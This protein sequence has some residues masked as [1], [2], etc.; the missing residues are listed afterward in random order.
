MFHELSALLLRLLLEQSTQS[1]TPSVLSKFALSLPL[2]FPSHYSLKDIEHK[3]LNVPGH[4][5]ESE[6]L[7]E[8]SC[9]ETETARQDGSL[10]TMPSVCR[11]HSGTAWRPWE[12]ATSRTFRPFRLPEYKTLMAPKLVTSRIAVHY[13][14][15]TQ[16]WWPPASWTQRSVSAR[17]RWPSH[18]WSTGVGTPLRT[19]VR[20]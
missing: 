15:F 7:S 20:P 13:T 11:R 17:E 2:Q 12:C 4:R 6:V 3:A 14:L 18:C 8:R 10:W 19:A 9:C 5:S 1:L 16:S